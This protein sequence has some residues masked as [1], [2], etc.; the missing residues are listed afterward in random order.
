MDFDDDDDLA[1][2]IALS[3]QEAEKTQR[4]K[5]APEVV[6]ISS[7]EDEV[8]EVA[9][10]PRKDKPPSK[11]KDNAAAPTQPPAG[12]GP[13]SFLGDRAQLERER[14]AR[15]KRL[16]G[17]SPPRPPSSGSG[18]DGADS[19]SGASGASQRKRPRITPPAAS[20]PGR[21]TFPDGAIL[22]TATQHAAP[23][24]PSP[25]I[26]LSELLGPRDDLAAAIVSAYP[27]R[28]RGGRRL[29]NV[30]PNWVRVCPPLRGG[31]G[32]MHMK[33][34]L[35]FGKGGG[36]RVVVGSAN[37]VPY[38]WRD[39]ENYVLFRTS[40]PRPP[41][42]QQQSRAPASGR[43]SRSPRCSSGAARHRRRGRAAHHASP[44]A[45]HH[46]TPS[47]LAT[48][49]DWSAV[50]AA[51]VP[52]VP[53]RWEGWASVLMTGQPRLMRAV[54]ALGCTT[55]VEPA[56]FE[57]KGKS[58]A[59]NGK[60]S[61]NTKGKG[62]AKAKDAG[63][64]LEL[65]CLTSSIGTYTPAWL[66]AFRLCARGAP[67]SL[68]A[69]L[70]RKGRASTPVPPT[71]KI[72][73]P[74]LRAL[75]ASAAGEAGGGTLFCRRAQWAGASF[76]RGAFCDI[77]LRS[78][79]NGGTGKEGKGGVVG[80]TKMIL[81]TLVPPL[82]EEEEDPDKTES[83]DSDSDSDIQIVEPPAKRAVGG[84]KGKEKAGSERG[85]GNEREEGKEKEKPHAWLYVGSH[86]F[87]PSAWGTLSGSGFNP[88]VNVTN[89]E[90]GVVLPLATRADADVA[91]AWVRPVRPYRAGD[92]PWIQE[93]SPFFR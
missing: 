51:L 64:D 54:Q 13:L 71:L 91:V 3:L 29:K 41:A 20:A 4:R 62:K 36:L 90:L 72:L 24:A 5:V 6:E 22:R 34:M 45:P 75:R 70:N 1:R 30:F 28:R 79:G 78:N 48:R 14:V 33:Y 61:G 39:I 77:V 2:A 8:V 37:L 60:G 63:W 55:E 27:R 69:W 84:A 85:K 83:D 92:G 56:A 81:G 59:V 16:R 23:D 35:L 86:N 19:D 46:A 82:A 74:S 88:V 57:F 26:R 49:W 9:L 66:G 32:C 18:S 53:G 7:D 42:P 80:H 65:E 68:E 31:R 12:A 76:P 25:S 67:R 89:Y 10:P 47:A 11:A 38:D 58:N 87:T 17:P 73:F 21:R 93:E 44:G 15:Q 43:G 52:S 50:R 40:R